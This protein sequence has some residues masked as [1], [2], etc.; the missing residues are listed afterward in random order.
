MTGVVEPATT[1]T[2]DPETSGNEVSM[3]SSETAV[4]LVLPGCLAIGGHSLVLTKSVRTQI[5]VEF[6]LSDQT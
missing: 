3:S 5:R 1:A 4:L 6:N 2:Y